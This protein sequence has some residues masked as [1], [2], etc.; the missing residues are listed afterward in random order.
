MNK[1]ITN[2]LRFNNKQKEYLASIGYKWTYGL[3][4]QEGTHFSIEPWVGVNHI[5]DIATNFE[6]DLGKD[7]WLYDTDFYN[8]YKPIEETD[9]EIW[10]RLRE[11]E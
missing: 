2:G 11:L 10:E 6:V 8:K 9:R 7:E 3:R 4:D 1:T 5:G